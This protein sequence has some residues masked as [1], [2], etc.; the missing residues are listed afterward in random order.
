MEDVSFQKRIKVKMEKQ[1]IEKSNPIYIIA[2]SDENNKITY[3]F[4]ATLY[5]RDKEDV[6]RI[7]KVKWSKELHPTYATNLNRVKDYM[8]GMEKYHEIEE[9]YSY[10]IVKIQTC[11]MLEKLENDKWKQ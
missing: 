1:I 9:G 4:G 3:F 8:T 11:L 6:L 2:R 5:G 7:F 10:F